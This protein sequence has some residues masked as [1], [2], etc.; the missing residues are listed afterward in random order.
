MASNP[1]LS[2]FS[3]KT[4]LREPHFVSVS[5]KIDELFQEM[6]QE[7]IYMVVVIDEHGG[8]MGILS[9][10]DLVEKIVGSIHDEYDADELPDIASIGDNVFRVQ[11]TT[12]LE[13][14]QDYFDVTL[15]VDDFDTLSGFLVGQIGH[16]PSEDES[17]EIAWKSLL[18]KVESI[19]E[20]RIETV[21]VVRGDDNLEVN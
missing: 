9:M 11:G 5:K 18:F 4:M 16:I 12:A 6:R 13:E 2:D 14:V 20:K 1:D 8:T 19:H 7:R 10:E 17:L 3:M 15:P 21:V